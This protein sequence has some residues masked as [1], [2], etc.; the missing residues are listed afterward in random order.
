ME[1]LEMKKRYFGLITL[2][3]AIPAIMVLTNTRVEV[4]QGLDK[5]VLHDSIVYEKSFNTLLGHQPNPPTLYSI[6]LQ[7]GYQIY[8]TQEGY[9]IVNR[10]DKVIVWEYEGQE[11]N[12]YEFYRNGE[13][14]YQFT[15]ERAES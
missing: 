13:L 10:G 12:H 3:L 7:D 5:I 1:S 9:E 2:L 8:A 4:K 11:T 14:I 6:R 15:D